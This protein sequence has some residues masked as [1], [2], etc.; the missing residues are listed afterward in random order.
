[1]TEVSPLEQRSAD[2]IRMYQFID[3][4][5]QPY[6]HALH[7]EVCPSCGFLMEG[8]DGRKGGHC[9]NCGFNPGCCA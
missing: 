1:M 8:V 7:V 5:S 4:F 3:P 9:K 6:R 2:P